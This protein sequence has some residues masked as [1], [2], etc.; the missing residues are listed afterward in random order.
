LRVAL[1][2]VVIAVGLASEAAAEVKPTPVIFV[3]GQ[4]GSAQQFETNAMRFS[5]NGYP[6][7]R[8]Y[9]YEYDTSES[10]NDAAIAGLDGFIDA[11]RARTGAAKVD[12]LAHSRGTT[13]MHSYLS[14]PER[15]ARVRRYV[16]FDGR[17][18]DAP[19]GGVPT[20][21]VWGEG[22]PSR[23]IDGAENVRFP[24]K[25]HTEVTT[26]RA[27]FSDVFEFLNGER[28]EARNVLP[29]N[30]RTVKVAG[31]AV[32]FPDNTGAAGGRLEVYE[33]DRATGQ[34][35]GRALYSLT[36]P[37]DGSFGPLKI[38]GRKRYEF[39]LTRAGSDYTVHN[40][41]EPF[42]RS[43]RFYRVLDAPVLRPFID[44]DPA[45]VT[46]AV[47]RM[48][49]FWGSGDDPAFV[50]SLTVGGLEVLNP[51][52]APR[53][54][55]I[56]AVF[57]FDKNRD[58]QSDTSASLA[59]FNSISFLTAVDNYIP[60]SPDASGTVAVT[61]T[62]RGNRRHSITTNVPN[63]PSLGDT[64]SVF[65]KDYPAKTYRSKQG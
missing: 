15:A 5:S 52:T 26:S 22:D 41:P 36:L 58:R 40:Y 42:E 48:R 24:N 49:E 10:S 53:Q 28:P 57:N 11:V 25:A 21:A 18:A 8:L 14:S 7:D 20:L 12:V 2:A 1:A 55:R 23:V 56:L 45:H 4:S 39:A 30:P 3:H 19:P 33:L 51:Q 65:F 6:H 17:T 60:A 63:W 34:R 27:A 31:R 50:D 38:N 47:T 16:N 29:Q 35:R 54:R 59:P 61:E 64:V 43:D 13:I 9:A 44:T 46:V 62:M 32:T 37:A